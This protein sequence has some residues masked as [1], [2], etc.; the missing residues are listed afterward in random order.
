MFFAMKKKLSLLLILFLSTYGINAQT[1]NVNPGAAPESSMTLEQLIENVFL[2]QSCASVSNITSISNSS[3]EYFDA[4]FNTVNNQKSFAYFTNVGGNFP[5]ARGVIMSSGAAT[6]SQGANTIDAFSG[7]GSAGTWAGDADIKTILDTRFGDNQ[8]TNNATIVEFDFVP[9]D[10]NFSFDYVFASEEYQERNNAGTDYESSTFQDGFAFILSGPGVTNDAGI[11]GKNIALLADG[12]TPVSAGTI[13][14]NAEVCAP[15]QNTG[16]HVAYATNAT[17]ANAPIQ[18]NGRTILLTASN[19]VVAGQTYHMKMVIADR[20]DSSYDSAVFL[21]ASTATAITVD[22]GSDRIVCL[23]DFP[24]VLSPTGTFGGGA[25][26]TWMFNG[27]PISG[28]TNTTYNAT[29]AG[30]YEVVVEDGSQCSSDTVIISTVPLPTVNV[31]VNGP[32]CDG[33]DAIY[34]LTG[35][36]NA[37][38]TYNINGGA[39]QTIVLNAAGIAIVQVNTVS[40]NTVINI[41]NIESFP[42]TITGNGLST[43]GG[44]NPTNCT[45]NILPI[46]TVPNNTNA[47]LINNANQNL[48]LTLMHTVPAGTVITISIS[49]DNN[50]GDVT[51]TDGTAS[52]NFNTGPND[53]LQQITFTTGA[54]TNTL[55][56]SRNG[57]GIWIDGVTYSYSVP[58]CAQVLNLSE[59]V[60]VNPIPAVPTITTVAPTCAADGASTITN[61]NV[62]LTYTFTPAGPTAGAG[63]VISGMVLGTGYT[64]TAGNGSCTSVA[65]ASFTNVTMLTTQTVPTITTVVPTCVADGN[66]TITNYNATIAYTFTPLGPTAGAGGAITGMTVGTAYTVT[67]G[68]GSC[69]SVASASFTNVAMLVTPAVPTITTIPPSCAADG[70]STITNYNAAL[71]YTFTPVGP[72]AGAGGVV[73]GMVLGTAYTVTAGNGSCTSVASAGFTNLAMLV[74]PAIPTIA[75]VAPTCLADGNS[76]ITNYNGALTYTFTPVGPTAG[77][78][79]IIS[80][81]TLGTGYTVTAGNGSCTS[82]ASAGFT[83]VAMLVT[84][85]VPTITTIP[86]SCVADGTSTITNYNGAL[87]YTF[88]P[89]GPTAG[90]GGV[91]SGIVLGTAYTITAGNGSCTSVASAEFTNLAMLATQPTPTINTVAPTCLAD[92]S[93]IITNYNPGA[94]YTFVPVGPTVGAGGV[95]SGMVLGTAY[96]VTANIGACVSAASAGFTNLSMLVTPAIPTITTVPPTCLADGNSSITNYNA[97]LTYTF[98][99]AGPIAGAG[100]VVSGMTLGTGYT[101]TAGNGSCTSVAS[102][103]ITNLAML[104]T[105]A[106]PTITTV[107]PTCA[108]DGTSTITNTTEP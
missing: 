15:A 14:N 108:T 52:Q 77:A 63:G 41:T 1:I 42:V 31:T 73:S 22:L 95:I 18:Y 55:G 49:R 50:A 68:N 30:T 32:L 60:V 33:D 72:T 89:V 27:N 39:I 67:A 90:A 46:G 24:Q 81:M 2:G 75:T 59:T 61:Y 12:V 105:P 35:T 57:G 29:Q 23:G 106:I 34:T 104:V 64:V 4:S 82:I 98:S 38:V 53:I 97:A 99:P 91:V 76:T 92:G 70:T 103:G 47:S 45:G 43:V 66:S 71:T 13:H 44:A 36:P 28:E 88:T 62:A 101:V 9:L 7:M 56:F 93:S 17:A 8:P 16:L 20:M 58:G 37:E 19:V 86:P 25:T 107:V 83:N 65:S 94:T 40:V 21:Q 100:G 102:A 79:G 3:V 69:T 48:V 26:F 6:A 85:A 10:T 5:S 54:A 78:G 96:T 11:T 80:G 87:T 51:I 74:T 84:P